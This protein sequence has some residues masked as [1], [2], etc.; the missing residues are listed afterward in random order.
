MLRI[1]LRNILRAGTRSALTLV[2]V[3]GGVA[4]FVSLA[5]ISD[6]FRRQ[7]DESI[8]R[9]KV[10]VIVQERGAATPV[11]SRVPERLLDDLRRLPGVR[12]ISPLTV[13]SIRLPR[14]PY[15]FIFGVGSSEPF[16]S[17]TGWLGTGMIEGTM[18]RAGRKEVVLGR[19]A[20]RR[21]KLAVGDTLLVGGK[22]P[23]RV[24]GVYW[25]GQGILDGGAVIDISTSQ[26]LLKRKGFVNIALVEGREKGDTARLVGVIEE[27]I[28][29]VEAI[30]AG[31]MRSRI[32]AVT[33]VDSFIV[34]VSV[35]SLLLSGVLILNTLLMAIS[36]RTREIGIL[37]AVGWSRG[38]IMRLIICEA[39][40]LGVAGGV[41]GYGL[42][43]PTLKLMALLPAMGAGLIPSFPPPSLFLSA[44]ALSGLIA[45]L[46]ALYPALFATRLQIAAALRF[47]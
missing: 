46:S 26:V 27:H 33:M 32:R 3:A 29:D 12:S 43:I 24:T 9:C 20:A 6:G 28:P 22:E 35:V 18:F 1:A 37:A 5:A 4:L 31:S 47:E 19:L 41:L 25:L 15:L 11:A 44:V 39:I 14:L 36:E 21:L 2:G 45:A 23:Y 16:V 30:P 42:A 7:L 40:V 17:I 34:A 38:M 10:D 13:G 8:A